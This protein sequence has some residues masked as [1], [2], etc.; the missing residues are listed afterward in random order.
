MTERNDSRWWEVEPPDHEHEP[1]T[2]SA[3]ED[4]EILECCDE[5]LE[6]IDVVPD[7]VRYIEYV[8]AR[9]YFEDYSQ[10]LSG[11]DIL[12]ATQSHDLF[13]G[14]VI[15]DDGSFIVPE[16]YVKT[17]DGGIWKFDIHG[18]R[19]TFKD[20]DE[21]GEVRFFES[22]KS[23]WI[24][25]LY[26]FE[27]TDE[28]GLPLIRDRE[29]CELEVTL[30]KVEGRDVYPVFTE[31]TVNGQLYG[32]EQDP[33]SLMNDNRRFN[34]FA[35][36]TT[37]LRAE[38]VTFPEMRWPNL[39]QYCVAKYSDNA[40]TK[41]QNIMDGKEGIPDE[42]SAQNRPEPWQ[43]RVPSELTGTAIG[44]IWVATDDIRFVND[45]KIFFLELDKKQ[46]S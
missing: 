28:K 39:W 36:V 13:S 18:R 21:Y 23:V 33:N 7:G 14:V 19:K 35:G 29:R 44:S 11:I 22:G 26:P 41:F 20:R 25:H 5:W 9:A 32:A 30:T 4:E 17:P 42:Y 31:I 27:E 40:A 43:D 24:P 46:D 45:A 8:N 15:M 10:G 38:V 3:D 2:C 6:G 34:E 12:D 1:P 37:E 16:R